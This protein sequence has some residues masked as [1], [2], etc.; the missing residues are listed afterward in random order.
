MTAAPGLPRTR[1]D[2]CP[3]ALQTH[4]AADG[5][6]AR[7]RVP[8]GMLTASQ[9]RVLAAAARDLG[10]GHLEMTSRG[11]LQLRGLAAGVGPEL[12]DRLAG[13]GLLPSA[14]HERVRNVLASTLSGRD[15]SG[16]LDARPWVPALD[17]GLCAD[18]GLADLPGRYLATLDD[19]RGDVAGLGGDVGL[20]ALDAGTVALLLAGTDS[21]LRTD[22]AG[23]VVLA[24][25]ATRAF[26]AERTAQGGTAWRLAELTDGPARVAARLAGTRAGHPTG[27]APGTLG[28]DPRD[29]VAVPAAPL[30][31]PV[32][33]VAQLD[34][35]TALIGVVPLG[36]LTA[37]QAELLAGLAAQ[38]QLTPWR[39]VVVPDLAEDAVDD[40]AVDLYRTGVVFD[41]ASPWLQVTTCAGSPGCAR[42]LADVRGDALAAVAAGTLPAGGA[43]QHWAGCARRCGSPHGEVVDVLAVAPSA[44][45]PAGYV[46][47]APSPPAPDPP[48]P[49]QPAPDQPAPDQHRVDEDL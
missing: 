16:H 2:A 18:P 29:L 27:S 48:A 25:A 11:N 42:S 28:V 39:S 22:P 19:G 10:D 31:G 13:A 44:D 26:A 32:G 30:V 43:R 36:R 45:A 14:T 20:L 47:T 7:V 3:G 41:A 35:R 49:D 24:L 5:G 15:G 9:L 12:G 6:L 8:G 40:A 34:G 23:A 38:V 21:G 37:G 17:A 46:V 33:A 1:V 4:P